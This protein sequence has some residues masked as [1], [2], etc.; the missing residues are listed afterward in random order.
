MPMTALEW[1]R[2]YRAMG[3]SPIPVP[4]RE[5][6]CRI[7]GWDKLLLQEPELPKFF[8]KDPTNIGVLLG[9]P[10]GGL[11]DVDLDSTE[12]VQLASSFLPPTGMVFGRPGKPASHWLYKVS[13]PGGAQ[14]FT[15]PVLKHVIAEYRANGCFTVFP[16]STHPTGEPIEFE[17][18]G[19]PA[20]VDREELIGK[21]QAMAA[22]SV[23]ARHWPP[24]SRH[25]ASLALSGCL[26]TS[27][28]DL[29]FTETFVRAVCLA[30]KDAEMAD[31]LTCVRTT[32]DKLAENRPILHW[33]AL[34]DA[35][36]P[37]V[38]DYM[39]RWLRP[40]PLE[41]TP[42]SSSSLPVSVI[43]YSDLANAERFAAQHA[44]EARYSCD[45]RAWFLWDGRRWAKDPG[46]TVHQ[47]AIETAKTL[48]VEA[49]KA[50]VR[51]QLFWAARSQSARGIRDMITVAESLLEVRQSVFDT[52]PWQFNCR[53]GTLDLRT[54][55]LRE[56]NP[57]DF[58]T[59]LAP[60]EFSPKAECP[61]FMGFLN[62]IVDGN[63]TLIA[64]LQRALGY[65]L[66]GSTAEQC[67]FLMLGSGA[68]GKSTLLN[69][70]RSVMGE[71]AATTAMNTLMVRSANSP[72]NDI[73]RLQGARFVTATE[74]ELGQRVAEAKIKHMTGGD[75]ISARY[76]YQ[77]YVEFLPEFKLWLA[78]NELPRIEGVDEGTWRRIRLILFN[79]TIPPNERDATLPLRLQAELP[80][81]L[82]WM[83]E[84]CLE[85]QRSG[86][87]PPQEVLLATRDYRTD[88]D[89]VAQFIEDDCALEDKAEATAKDLYARYLEWC[90]ANGHDPLKQMIFGQRLK[91]RGLRQVRTR[92]ARSWSGIRLRPPQDEIM[93]QYE[94]QTDDTE[95]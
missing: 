85:W 39:R 46:R 18:D 5:K 60:V 38:V 26:L 11:V 95:G 83:L 61:T 57:S 16:G 54:G 3:F 19:E 10:S 37:L 91:A 56:H 53:N 90:V 9:E 14:K 64:F 15:D 82:N 84:G 75:M 78:T 69:T 2:K 12:A 81:I 28:Y 34:A 92:K 62:R 30:A 25:S 58:I 66:T 32:S 21:L 73:A 7:R 20:L 48:A 17:A 49:G 76:L 42:A 43:P 88:M 71:Y 47:L 65:S 40:R 4:F 44:A 68:N 23:F 52:H 13:E 8:G 87:K 35:M 79:V 70:V 67:L 6:A 27:G 80:G 22:A 63:Q 89:L 45:S 50:G 29:A 24:G 74:A 1:A 59:R 51:E 55:E 77:E 94:D 31:R 33:R 72:S 41:I 86:L 93:W 36:N